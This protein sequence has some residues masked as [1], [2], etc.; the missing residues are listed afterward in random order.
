MGKIRISI[1]VCFLWVCV[2]QRN[3][4]GKGERFAHNLQKT[5]FCFDQRPSEDEALWS[6]RCALQ[7]KGYFASHSQISYLFLKY[8]FLNKHL[9]KCVP[10][11]YMSSIT[12]RV[13]S[14]VIWQCA[15]PLP[16]PQDSVRVGEPRSVR[17]GGGDLFGGPEPSVRS[18]G[19]HPEPR[20]LGAQLPHQWRQERLV[21]SGP[22]VVGHPLGLHAAPRPR[23]RP[24]RPAQL[25]VPGVQG[26]P[27]LDHALHAR[28]RLQPQRTWVKITS[29]RI[30]EGCQY[31][32]D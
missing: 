27:E 17:P 11:I 31:I 21:R 8:A 16:P 3:L 7:L 20:Q 5:W 28:G 23:L 26:R 6:K 24:L 13:E 19:G 25:D 15:Y 18:A 12:F 2:E 29:E 4:E 10:W 1:K 22:G 32:Q 30:P 14:G 9:L